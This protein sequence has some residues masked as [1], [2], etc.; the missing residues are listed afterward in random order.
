MQKGG[1]RMIDFIKNAI[2][3]LKMSDEEFALNCAVHKTARAICKH[4]LVSYYRDELEMPLYMATKKRKNLC[5]LAQSR[6]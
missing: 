2:N 4:Y 5:T 6:K 1:N 3:R